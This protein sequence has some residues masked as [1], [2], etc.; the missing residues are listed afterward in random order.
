N[1]LNDYYIPFIIFVGL[2]GNM[3]SCIVFLTTHL[4]MRS[5]SYYLA[6]LAVADFGFLTM[7]L[8]VYLSNA[9]ILEVYNQAGW[10]QLI[11]YVS[12]VCGVLSVWLIV[13]FTV[14]R[15]IAVQYPLQRP[16]ICTVSRAKLIICVIVTIALISQSYTFITAGIVKRQDGTGECALI[17]EHF[18]T[19]QTI[20][21]IDTIVALI[22][23]FILIVV[24]NT[25]IAR[26]LFLFRKRFQNRMMLGDYLT[27]NDNR[28]DLNLHQIQYV[29][30]RRTTSQQSNNSTSRNHTSRSDVSGCIHSGRH[31]VSTR[32]Q[33]NI[34]KMLLLISSVF[35]LLNLPSYVARIYVFFF[36]SLW[37]E[38]PPTQL[39][40]MQQFFM[41]LYYTNFSIN[42]LLYAMCG[43]TFRRC[44]W[45]MMRKNLKS[46]NRTCSTSQG[47]P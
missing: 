2:L 46:L 22:G 38:E 11:L 42:F 9:A 35:I 10:C 31:F 47:S 16:Q 24:M 33:Q 4:K 41:L 45:K 3:L 7:L 14:E 28:S 36:F 40:C 37:E 15:F 39:W 23:P 6:A 20:S 8:L 17:Q 5:S 26:N 27:T 13:A 18:N 30:S 12:S 1:I 44:L 21:I 43:I 25:M 29:G 34:T 32:N 19:M